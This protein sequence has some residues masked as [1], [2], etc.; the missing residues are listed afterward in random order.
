MNLMDIM[1]A[2]EHYLI[3]HKYIS[4]HLYLNEAQ[5]FITYL[6]LQKKSISDVDHNLIFQFIDQKTIGQSTKKW[7]LSLLRNFF[8]F[9]LQNQYLVFPTNP[10][11]FIRFSTIDEEDE[12][13]PIPTETEFEKLVLLFEDPFFA[14]ENC[15][16]L[17]I[18][19]TG[20]RYEN[21]C[22]LEQENMIKTEQ[23]I[24]LDKTKTKYAAAYKLKVRVWNTLAAY[25]ETKVSQQSLFPGN[26]S[27]LLTEK[28][29]ELFSRKKFTAALNN[30]ASKAG[31]ERI[32]IRTLRRMKA[33]SVARHLGIEA[34]QRSM[35][36][37][38][39]KSTFL[40]VQL[41]QEEIDKE[42][43]QHPLKPLFIKNKGKE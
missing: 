13:L 39:S 36:H 42:L 1:Q 22:Q 29:G 34:A 17:L 20:A 5:K 6:H 18:T 27:Y 40:Y 41:S 8:D 25:A 12:Y 31:I 19:S 33:S 15:Y 7:H 11:N 10:C 43:D 28:D 32:N 37:I 21:V 3:R 35:K 24:I 16:F 26:S 9:L 23:T 4:Y 38:A 14:L 30:L 2:Y